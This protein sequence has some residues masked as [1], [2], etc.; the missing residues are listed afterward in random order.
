MPRVNDA[1]ANPSGA[2]VGNPGD[3][4][5]RPR[6]SPGGR[7][8]PSTR[9]CSAGSPRRTPRGSS[10]SSRSRRSTTS[11]MM[12]RPRSA[13]RRSTCTISAWRSCRAAR[14][15]AGGVGFEIFDR[16]GLGAT[17]QSQRVSFQRALQ[18]ELA[19]T[20]GALDG[21]QPGARAPGVAGIHAV[22]PRP[23]GGA[24]FGEPEARAGRRAAEAQI[25][26][27]QRL[28]A[29][30]VPGLDIGRVVVTD[31]HG[32]TLSAPMRS[33]SVVPPARAA[34]R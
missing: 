13:C 16:Q 15:I 32:L 29:A 5:C 26:G 30:A 14:R 3:T 24:C 31:Q 1:D 18:G 8:A 21:V 4:H 19:R 25:F 22:P 33:R 6:C 28:V 9:C 12:A 11:S 23:P 7:C 34:C 20:I 10:P 17:E 2:G 27:I